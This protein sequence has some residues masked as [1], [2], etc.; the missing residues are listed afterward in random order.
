MPITRKYSSTRTFSSEAL[1]AAATATSV[2]SSRTSSLVRSKSAPRHTQNFRRTN[3]MMSNPE[4]RREHRRINSYGSYERTFSTSVIPTNYDENQTIDTNLAFDNFDGGI[5]DIIETRNLSPQRR[6]RHIS[7][8]GTQVENMNPLEVVEK[9]VPGPRGLSIVQ[10]PVLKQPS[11]KPK[12]DYTQSTTAS[13]RRRVS[14]I[15]SPKREPLSPNALKRHGAVRRS[16]IVH[17]SEEA[18]HPVSPRRSLREVEPTSPRDFH[19]TY[20]D[21]ENRIEKTVTTRQTKDHGSVETTTIV[22][23]HTKREPTPDLPESNH[24][25]SNTKANVLKLRDE[26][27]KSEFE[28]NQLELKLENIINA[29]KTLGAKK[30]NQ[31]IH[32]VVRN[33]IPIPVAIPKHQHD[34]LK[35]PIRVVSNMTSNTNTEEGFSDEGSFNDDN[36]STSIVSSMAT[37]DH[38]STIQSIDVEPP[39]QDIQPETHELPR[40]TSNQDIKIL[41]GKLNAFLDKEIVEDKNDKG[42]N[43]FYESLLMNMSTTESIPGMSSRFNSN[44]S[45]DPNDSQ[46]SVVPSLDLGQNEHQKNKTQDINTS[47]KMRHNPSMAQDLKA[48]HP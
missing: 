18:Q 40:D 38:L 28:K 13:P 14:T 6:Y 20:E 4:S 1:A 31:N 10:V 41:N 27:K 8:R 15:S 3:S 2:E 42:N 36:E 12:K 25:A 7:N 23:R 39:K 16:N 32:N 37:Y 33:E 29:E 5:D 30:E 44:I 48:S 35:G 26:V 22:R 9:Y 43:M 11:Q 17:S 19:A 24:N 21:D 34:K 46:I 47:F 45:L